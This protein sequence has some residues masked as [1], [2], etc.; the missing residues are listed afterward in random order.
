MGSQ[1][2]VAAALHADVPVSC[3]DNQLHS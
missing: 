1:T 2:M 3:A